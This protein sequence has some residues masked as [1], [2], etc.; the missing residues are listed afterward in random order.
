MPAGSER[1]KLI[2]GWRQIPE[3]HQSGTCS[4]TRESAAIAKRDGQPL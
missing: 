2:R 1:R 4:G 3:R